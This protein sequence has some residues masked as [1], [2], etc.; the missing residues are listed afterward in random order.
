M[1]YELRRYDVAPTKLPALLD[2]FGSF[3]VHKWKE[4]GFRLIGFWTPA[5]GEKSNQLVYIWGWESMEERARKR[6]AWSA[7]PEREKKWAETQKDGPLVNRVHNQLMEPTAYSQMDRGEAYG[8][9]AASR[10]PYLFEL[11]EY[12]AMPQKIQNITDRFGNFT[13]DAFKKHGFRQVGYWKNVIGANDHQLIYMLAWESFEERLQ[14]FDTF[15]KD[16]ERI[17]VFAESEKNGPIVENVSNALLR[18]TA[19]SPMK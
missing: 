18:P 6:A 19:F 15:L 1:L 2:R 5:V 14:K 17:R 13:C 16:P 4:Y 10:K 11:R 12:Q 9:D 3:T 8:P 7:D